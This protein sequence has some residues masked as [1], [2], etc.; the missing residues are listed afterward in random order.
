MATKTTS[1]D[2]CPWLRNADAWGVGVE[3]DGWLRIRRIVWGR[4]VARAERRAGEVIRRV[5]IMVHD[6][7]T[8]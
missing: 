2:H 1:A 5:T 4:V 8:R 3:R 7:V 6:R